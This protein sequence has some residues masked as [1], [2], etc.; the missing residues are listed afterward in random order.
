MDVQ[1]RAKAYVDIGQK[2]APKDGKRREFLV[3]TLIGVVGLAIAA[4]SLV[5]TLAP[6]PDPVAE[7]RKKNPDAQ[8]Q[9]VQT[10]RGQPQTYV[11]RG[12]R[13]PGIPGVGDDGRWNAD[14]SIYG[15]PGAPMAS[16]YT[17]VEVFGTACPA[18]GLDYLFDN[19]GT[20]VHHRIVV[21][22]GQTV[23]G[24][25]GG[26]E[27]IFYPD[28]PEEVQDLSLSRDRLLVYTNGR[29]QLQSVSCEEISA[30]TP[31]IQP[32]DR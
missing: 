14:L 1:G 9:L 18:V 21:Q 17:Q 23:S 19:Q 2:I 4:W 5:A 28:T 11:I 12:C 6:K 15:I 10:G 25:T 26:A 30:V 32:R 31:V 16:Q 13:N 27:N 3:G 29:Y 7:C 8:G 20:T 24:Y 22:T